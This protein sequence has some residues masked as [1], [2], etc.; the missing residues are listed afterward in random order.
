MT[1]AGVDARRATDGGHI[2]RRAKTDARATT[3]FVSDDRGGPGTNSGPRVVGRV[4]ARVATRPSARLVLPIRARDS[5]VARLE[6]RRA[7]IPSAVERAALRPV[8]AVWASLQ[9]KMGSS[10]SKSSKKAK[11]KTPPAGSVT[12]VD[13]QVLGL[14]TQKRK[15]N[16]YAKRV[17]VRRAHRD[18]TAPANRRLM[19]T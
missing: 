18:P 7:R 16:A 14:K 2:A 19:A 12:E 5:R 13:R 9:S 8:P 17:E 1:R 10:Y 15:L 11:K 6:A 3:S 4:K